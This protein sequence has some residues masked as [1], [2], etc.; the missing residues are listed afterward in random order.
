MPTTKT[1]PKSRDDIERTGLGYISWNFKV[2]LCTTTGSLTSQTIF[3]VGVPYR[4]GDVVTN[5]AW[6]ISTAAAGTA[7]TSAIM[8]ISDGVTMLAQ[9]A[10]VKASTSWAST[11]PQVFALSAAYVIPADGIYY[12]VAW[13]NGTWGTTQPAVGRSG[14]TAPSFN[15]K[16]NYATLGTSQS[17]FPAN[18]AAVT[19]S[20]SGS[21]LP[22]FAAS[23]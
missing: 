2:D 1:S 20:G 19:L 5:L 11:G 21:P 4:A 23:S 15:S 9:T 22:F 18:A 14:A 7:P 17:S 16:F 13:V 3:A 8:G 10:D 6:Q 12:H